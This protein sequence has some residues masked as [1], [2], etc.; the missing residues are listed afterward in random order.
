MVISWGKA[1]VDKIKS[2]K[3]FFIILEKLHN[4]SIFHI[5]K[6]ILNC[7]HGQWNVSDPEGDVYAFGQ[8][9]NIFE[10]SDDKAKLIMESSG[11]YFVE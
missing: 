6:I 3:T 11:V 1:L 10:I 7:E 2:I 8:W 5:F 4:Q 9:G